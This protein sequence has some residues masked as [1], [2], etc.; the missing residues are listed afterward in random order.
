MDNPYEPGTKLYRTGD[1]TRWYPLGEMEFLGRIDKQVKIR[2]YRIEL[3]E[4]ENRLLQLPGVVSC[5]V[6]DY[7]DASQEG[8]SLLH[9]WWVSRRKF[10]I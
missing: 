5:A 9:F 4:I 10:Q 8:S 7:E 6:A 2:G 1:L 3:A